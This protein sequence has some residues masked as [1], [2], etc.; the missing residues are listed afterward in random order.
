MAQDGYTI[1]RELRQLSSAL[2]LAVGSIGAHKLRSFLTLLG[3]I[4]GVSSVIMV[5]AAIEGLGTYAEQT[6]ASAFGTASFGVA[7]IA[8][9]GDMSR[10]AY[11]DKMKHNKPIHTDDARFAEEVAGSRIYFSPNRSRNSWAMRA[12]SSK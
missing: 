9:S 7:Q 3:T 5:G 2:R 4:I 8:M 10:R 1:G 12:G 11:I 6:T